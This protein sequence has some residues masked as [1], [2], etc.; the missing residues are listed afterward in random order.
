[1]PPAFVSTAVGWIP[2]GERQF[3]GTPTQPA[4]L[5]V[6]LPAGPLPVSVKGMTPEKIVFTPL[7]TDHDLVKKFTTFEKRPLPEVMSSRRR[8]LA[9]VMFVRRRSRRTILKASPR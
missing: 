3:T 1:M 8:P 7:A 6:R 9:G 4:F 2:L 5:V